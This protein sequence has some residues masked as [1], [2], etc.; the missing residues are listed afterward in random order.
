MLSEVTDPIM[1]VIFDLVGV[2]NPESGVESQP[3]AIEIRDGEGDLIDSTSETSGFTITLWVGSLEDVELSNSEARVGAYGQLTVEMR[4]SHRVDEGGG[5]QMT[6]PKWDQG[7]ES[8]FREEPEC[9]VITQAPSTISPGATCQFLP[10]NDGQDG[11]D[12][13]SISNAFQAGLADGEQVT[14][15]LDGVRNS[16]ST[17]GVNSIGILTREAD[18]AVV[19]EAEGISYRPTLP[20]DSPA[21]NW[22]VE[23]VESTTATLTAMDLSITIEN[24]VPGGSILRVTFPP[25]MKLRDE[26]QTEGEGFFL[27]S[28]VRKGRDGR[29]LQDWNISSAS[30]P[31]DAGPTVTIRDAFDS[32]QGAGTKM[33]LEFSQI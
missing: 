9:E 29:D 18:G 11:Q 27:E 25:E 2:L 16:P 28:V 20:A 14:F 22:E 6:F 30:D 32:S 1:Y 23:L 3:I 8:Y 17:K 10:G 13:I 15:I 31:E 21:T 26:S 4:T 24:P 33:F 19:D 7:S 5:I 12:R